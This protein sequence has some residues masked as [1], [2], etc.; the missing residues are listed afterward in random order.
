MESLKSTTILHVL[1]CDAETITDKLES[2]LTTNNLD[3]RKLVG[4]GYDGAAVFSGVNTGVQ[5][6]MHVHSTHA[7]YIH[8]D[9]HR[10]Q[11][12]SIQ[13]ADCVSELKKVFGL[14]GN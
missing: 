5:A 10:L 7:M 2:F 3:Y 11:L 4:Q 12:V 8:C 1:A 14:M 9:C 6:R 13:V